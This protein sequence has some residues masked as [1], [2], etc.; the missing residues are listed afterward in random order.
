MRKPIAI[1]K[2]N[3]TVYLD[4]QLT[5]AT[6]HIIETPNLLTLVE[7]A[8]RETVLVG[9][10][11]AVEKDLGRIVGETSLVA[12]SDHDEIVYAKRL[13]RD[14]FTRFVKNKTLTPTGCVTIILRKT[15]DGYNLWS[16]WCGRLVPM[17][18]GDGEAMPK[19]QG[20]WRNHALVYD[21]SIIQPGTVT[22][23]C[24]WG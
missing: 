22:P 24:P 19:S 14:K 23:V 7:E 3:I 1:S 4:D 9:G 17:S 8:L 10:N 13:H 16:A 20:F 12:T 15:D 6:L 11:V 18:P 21:E 5:N 2:N